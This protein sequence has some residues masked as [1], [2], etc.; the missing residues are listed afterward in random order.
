MHIQKC[1][2]SALDNGI[3]NNY[4]LQLHRI[5]INKKKLRM[6][7]AYK[8]LDLIN[9]NKSG[10]VLFKNV[11]REKFYKEIKN[12]AVKKIKIHDLRY[13]HATILLK[14]G[15]NP[16]ITS[17]RLG[18]TDISLTFRVYSHILP[19]AQEEAVKN[20]GKNSFC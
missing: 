12:A 2:K 6:A 13:T 8:D 14:H 7:S 5:Q 1:Y 11:F 4:I 10:G 17:E 3:S 9:C 19:N 15:V 18:H 20:F 16:K